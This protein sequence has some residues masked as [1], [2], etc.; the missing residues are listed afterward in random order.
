MRP[1][2]RPRPS[3]ETRAKGAL[4]RMRTVGVSGPQVDYALA[5]LPY[6]VNVTASMRLPSGSTTNAA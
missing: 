2:Y 5:N 4:L 3:F 6:C 1:R